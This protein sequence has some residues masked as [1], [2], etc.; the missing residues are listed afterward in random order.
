MVVVAA[1]G[2]VEGVGVKR[3]MSSLNTGA[4]GAAGSSAKV[5][6]AGAGL[7]TSTAAAG[8]STVLRVAFCA[9]LA[10]LYEVK[11]WRRMG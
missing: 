9:A 3:L 2:E 10:W 4:A 5:A 8:A 6:T 11:L 7:T 1:G